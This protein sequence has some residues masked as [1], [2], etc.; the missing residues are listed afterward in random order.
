MKVA[1]RAYVVPGA[2]SI[3]GKQETLGTEM[4]LSEASIEWDRRMAG[5]RERHATNGSLR[6]YLRAGCSM[7][8]GCGAVGLRQ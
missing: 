3:V 8:L 6:R 5:F 1:A 2:Q 4:V 7:W